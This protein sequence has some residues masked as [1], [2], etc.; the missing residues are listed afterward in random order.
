MTNSITVTGVGAAS[1][2]P[3]QAQVTIGVE[4]IGR[5]VADARAAVAADTD[6]VLNA[7]RAHGIADGDMNTIGYSIRPEYDHREGRRLRG[8]RV[9]NTLDVRIRDLATVGETIDAAA[10]AG[11]DSIV[12]NSL[13]FTQADP[14]DLDRVA[15][16]AAWDDA[17]R[18]A[19]QLAEL[20][21]HRLSH[22]INITEESHPTPLPV[23]AMITEAAAAATPIEPG[24]ATVT[25]T[26]RVEFAT[27]V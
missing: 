26:I 27:S 8:Y 7:L 25:I 12:V 20:A 15:R 17:R 23:R 24:E 22:A 11:S 3:D 13:S 9:T 14:T 6:A 1:G 2:V 21:G 5:S 18:R 4:I 19:R 10:A 16:A